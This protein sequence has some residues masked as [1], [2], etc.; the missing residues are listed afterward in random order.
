MFIKRM[1]CYVHRI[2]EALLNLAHSLNIPVVT[3]W[4]FIVMSI[5]WDWKSP[6]LSVSFMKPNNYFIIII[7]LSCHQHG[8]PWPSFAT[9]PYCSSLLVGPQGYIQYPHR[10]AVCRFEPVSLPL[11]DHVRGS[12]GEHHLWARPASPAVSCM[13]G[14][15][16]FDSFRDR[17]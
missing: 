2:Y 9:H 3:K 4:L 16:N 11:L 5:W 15:S 17:K 10:A 7:I 6:L 8:Y 1:W 12:I 14:S 13:S